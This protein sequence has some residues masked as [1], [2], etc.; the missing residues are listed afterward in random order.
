MRP[1]HGDPAMKPL[2]FGIAGGS[3]SG[4]STVARKV[5][6]QLASASV[7]FIEMDSY[8]RNLTH[9]AFEERRHVNWDHPD[10]FDFDLLVEQLHLLSAGEAIDTP[11]YDFTTHARAGR[12]KRVAP[13]QVV[14][15]DGI[16]L[17]V[18]QRVRDLCDVKVYVDADADVRV[19]RRIRRDMRKRG[20]PVEEIIEQYLTTVRPM[21]LEF[22]EPSKR[23]ADVIVPRGGQNEVAIE[24]IVAKIRQ[25]LAGARGPTEAF[26]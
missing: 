8:Y 26:A 21:H 11:V 22:V 13:A 24:M 10:A 3:G 25:R 23:W 5:A 20:R 7:A 2:I 16:L 1:R 14:V 17:F 18:D 6:E 4:K 9:L 15:I 12:T 19:L